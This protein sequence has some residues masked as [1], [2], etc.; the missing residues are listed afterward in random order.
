MRR[1]FAAS[2]PRT[3]SFQVGVFGLM[4]CSCWRCPPGLGAIR[5]ARGE[6]PE[7]GRELRVLVNDRQNAR[8]ELPTGTITMLFSDLEGSTRLLSLLGDRYAEVLSGQ[9]GLLRAAFGRHHGT[10]MG[11]E[12]DSFFVV[13]SSAVTPRRLR[14]GAARARRAR[15]A[16]GRP[17]AG[18]DGPAHG[19][20]GGHEDGYVGMDVHRAARIAAS[21]HGGQ[22]I[23]SEVTRQLWPAGCPA[24]TRPTS[25]GTGSR[26]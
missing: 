2:L 19:G 20:A 17:A 1:D 21:A 11:T 12:G 4:F 5:R 15:V 23:M 8:V 13:F 3:R 18:T 6:W 7:R 25:A 9:R 16:E 26:T 10:E 22:V 24:S 14:G